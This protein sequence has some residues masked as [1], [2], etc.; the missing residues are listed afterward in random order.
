MRILDRWVLRVFFLH[1]GTVFGAILGL[2][3][4]LDVLGHGDELAETAAGGTPVI[5]QT[6]QLALLQIPFLCSQFSPF[7]SLIAALLTVVSLQSRGEWFPLLGAGVSGFRAVAPL[8]FGVA[9]VGF[10]MTLVRQYVLPSL[11]PVR[12]ALENQVMHQRPWQMVGLGT[13]TTDGTRLEIQRYF[14]DALRMESVEIHGRDSRG[15]DTLILAESAVWK[16]GAWQL[17]GGMRWQADGSQKEVSVFRHPQL[18]PQDFMRSYFAAVDPLQLSSADLREIR[19][20]DPGHRQASVLLWSQGAFPWV[21]ILLLMLG[22][23]LVFRPDR[24]SP[25]DGL[26][27]GFLISLLWF[28]LDLVLRDLG[29][30]GFLGPL[31]GGCGAL[32]LGILLLIPLWTSHF[33]S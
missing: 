11:S 4:I 14:A 24:R 21:H 9:L 32:F 16:D 28:V 22:L 27:W 7:L 10:G 8:I 25:S 31:L 18:Q 15:G 2:F 13:R 1:L 30:R 5:L 6:L 33:R 17:Q 29:S 12:E 26:A 19:R 20:R 3:S 23:P